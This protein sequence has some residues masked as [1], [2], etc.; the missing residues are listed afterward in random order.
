[1]RRQAVRD[2]TAVA[3]KAA[4]SGHP[5][6]WLGQVADTSDDPRLDIARIVREPS[7]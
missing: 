1:M 5:A 3:Q 2:L 7:L 4:T 6:P